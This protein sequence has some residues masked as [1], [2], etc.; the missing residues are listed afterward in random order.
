ML[1]DARPGPAA[2]P[3]HRAGPVRSGDRHEASSFRRRFCDA[4]PLLPFRSR[5]RQ[6]NA[7]P[8]DLKSARIT[9]GHALHRVDAE[10]FRPVSGQQDARVLVLG[11]MPGAASL[12]AAPVLRASAQSFWPIMGELVGADPGLPYAQRLDRLTAAGIALW[13]V[14]VAMRARRQPRCAIRDDTARRQRFAAFFAFPADH[15]HGAVQRRQGRTELPAHRIAAALP[16][17]LELRLRAPAFDQPGECLDCAAVKL[18]AWRQ[19]PEAGSWPPP[20]GAHRHAGGRDPPGS[21]GVDRQTAG[22]KSR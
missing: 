8:E 22:A 17:A 10:G 2:R 7:E 11:S 21:P 5:A 4:W 19:A 1:L 14:F 18:A 20:R 13:D 16:D 3:A 15:S 12:Q 9:H 6:F